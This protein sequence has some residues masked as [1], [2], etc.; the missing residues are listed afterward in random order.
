MFWQLLNI[1]F[2][3]DGTPGKQKT[4]FIL[5]PGAALAGLKLI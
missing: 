1:D 3:I 2:K 5:N 4:L